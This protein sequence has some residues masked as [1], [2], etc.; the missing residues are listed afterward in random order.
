MVRQ[1]DRF[2]LNEASISQFFTRFSTRK[3]R[4]PGSWVIVLA[5]GCT[6]FIKGSC[7]GVIR[8]IAMAPGCTDVFKDS[9]W[10]KHVVG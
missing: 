4:L 1:S 8:S 6:L 9:I 5:R 3:G 2:V 10:I 7:L